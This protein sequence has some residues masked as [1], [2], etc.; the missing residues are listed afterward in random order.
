MAGDYRW[1]CTNRRSDAEILNEI[2]GADTPMLILSR[3]DPAPWAEGVS[4]P[5]SWS[6]SPGAISLIEPRLADDESMLPITRP[7]PVPLCLLVVPP[8]AWGAIV[9]SAGEP[10]RLAKGQET[11]SLWDWML[12]ARQAGAPLLRAQGAEEHI[13]HT[14]G[15]LPRRQLTPT[16][17][18]RFSSIHREEIGNLGGCDFQHGKPDVV[19]LKAGLFLWHDAL[20]ESHALSQSIEGMGRHRSGDYWHAI[21]HRREP[22]YGNSKY[23]FRRVGSHPIFPELGRLAGPLISQAA[24]DWRDRLLRNGWDPFAFVDFCEAIATRKQPRWEA[25]AEKIQ[26]LEMLLLLDSTYRDAAT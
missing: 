25:A 26:E 10:C 13:L 11:A 12:S 15:D 21:M 1:V 22:D 8:A 2:A 16:S 23:W 4:M 6:R 19:A 3:D 7:W 9:V 5:L 20:G 18:W 24:P 14:L 17:P